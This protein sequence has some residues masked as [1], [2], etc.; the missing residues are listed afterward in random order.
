[1]PVKKASSSAAA[2]TV[3]GFWVAAA[4]AGVLVVG[5][6]AFGL[7]ATSIEDWQRPRLPRVSGSF[8]AYGPRGDCACLELIAA[9]RLGSSSD[10]GADLLVRHREATLDRQGLRTLLERVAGR[11]LLPDG[12]SRSTILLGCDRDL[13]VRSIREVIRLG[14]EVGIRR[15]EMRVALERAPGDESSDPPGTL[16]LPYLSRPS[17]P[18]EELQADGTPMVMVTIDRVVPAAGTCS[19][20]V[21]GMTARD[22]DQLVELLDD[23]LDQQ[24]RR[25][26]IV[27]WIDAANA[28]PWQR[29]AEVLCAAGELAWRR[30]GDA[31]PV[32]AE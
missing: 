20:I 7:V 14:R 12:T 9:S 25:H 17:R 23:R 5:V 21:D 15:M 1:M 28:V 16:P 11:D 13:E 26:Q 2:G 4:I 29:V 10:V 8:P 30:G 18:F 3:P 6:A 27:I 31:Y 24:E 19:L 32:L 22:L